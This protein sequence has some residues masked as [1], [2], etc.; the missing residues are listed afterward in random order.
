MENRLQ[1]NFSTGH[2]QYQV[3][4]YGLACAPNVFQCMVNDVQRDFMDK[5]V[6]IDI[7]ILIY[8]SDLQSHISHV[9]QFLWQLLKYQILIKGENC[10]FHVQEISF[11]GYI[12][13]QESGSMDDKKVKAI[14]KCLLTRR[15][16]N[17]KGF[18]ICLFLRAIYFFHSWVQHH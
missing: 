5:F 3:T 4:P 15:L 10:R 13:S 18:R 1:Y 14:I 9:C 7:D 8:S 16:R 12:V 2:H 6:I 17:Y 11:L